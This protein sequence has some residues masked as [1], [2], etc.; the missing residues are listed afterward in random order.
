MGTFHISCEVENQGDLDGGNK[1]NTEKM[2]DG[3]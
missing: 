1:P 3:S 2:Q